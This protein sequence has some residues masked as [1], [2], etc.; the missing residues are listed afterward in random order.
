MI[1][2]LSRGKHV[3]NYLQMKDYGIFFGRPEPSP[4]QEFLTGPP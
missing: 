3:D 1:L 2:P 4:E